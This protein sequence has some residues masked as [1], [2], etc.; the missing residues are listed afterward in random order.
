[1]K[2]AGEDQFLFLA[3]FH[4]IGCALQDMLRCRW[5]EAVLKEIDQCRFVGHR[6]QLLQLRRGFAARQ[7]PAEQKSRAEP[8]LWLV[9]GRLLV[10]AFYHVVLKCVGECLGG[11]GVDSGCRTERCEKRSAIDVHSGIPRL[12]LLEIRTWHFSRRRV[13]YCF[14]S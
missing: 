14:R 12:K 13:Y 7:G 3:F 6:L 4:R 8:N 9:C 5:C 10:E 2:K 11:H 1:M